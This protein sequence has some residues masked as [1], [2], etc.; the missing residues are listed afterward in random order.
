MFE[1]PELHDESIAAS[2]FLRHL[3]KL[4]QSTGV[5]DFSMKVMA[6]AGSVEIRICRIQVTLEILSAYEGSIWQPSSVKRE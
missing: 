5:K 4:L 2:N 6:A 1:Y 3:N